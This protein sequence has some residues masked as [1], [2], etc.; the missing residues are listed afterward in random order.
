MDQE[1]VVIQPAKGRIYIGSQDHWVQER[2]GSHKRAPVSRVSAAVFLAHV[3]RIRRG[4][5]EMDRGLQ[6]FSASLADIEKALA[7]KKKSDPREKPPKHYQDYLDVFSREQ[8]DQ[9]P[10]HRSGIDHA[11]QLERGPDEKEKN[12]PWGPLYGMS[13]EELIVLRR[14]LTELLDKGFIRAS[15]SP[16]LAPVLFVRKPGGG[17]RFCVDYR[18]LKE[19]T[20]KDRYPLPLIDETLRS[21]SKA[22]WLTKLDVI[23]AFHKVRVQ[24]GDEWKTRSERD[25]GYTNG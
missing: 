9:L 12:P 7:P 13:R 16:A 10:P 25:M 14:T 11:I 21:L 1:E 8:A 24:E 15:S 19:I 6:V 5:H 22:K 2:P 18:G 3:R 23:A 20:K 17:L 4:R